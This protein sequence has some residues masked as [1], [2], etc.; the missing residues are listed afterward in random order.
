MSSSVAKPAT[1][2]LA[3]RSIGLGFIALVGIVNP[4]VGSDRHTDPGTSRLSRAEL[5][6]RVV[7][8]YPHPDPELRARITDDLSGYEPY[9]F[10]TRLGAGCAD[11]TSP[12]PLTNFE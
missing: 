2:R 3:S 5:I 8:Y 11:T 4:T 1:A 6:E 9:P 10:A 7:R 12:S